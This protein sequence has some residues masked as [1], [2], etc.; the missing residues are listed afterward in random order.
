MKS[1]ILQ[2]LLL[3]S[4]SMVAVFF[5]LETGV[6]IFLRQAS[7]IIQDDSHIV[8]R[9]K[10]NL[11]LRIAADTEKLS[12]I[13]TNDHGFI[14]DEWEIE[15][16]ATTLRIA[17]LGDSFTAGHDVDY[18][19]N[20]SALLGDEL[21]EKIGEKV[22]SLNFGVP[23]QGTGHALLTY[24]H[25][26]AEFK[27]DLVILWFYMGNDFEDNL[28]FEE[29]SAKAGGGGGSLVKRIARKSQLANF[30]VNRLAKIPA[31]A[32][33]L[34]GRILTRVGHDVST[35]TGN[36][37]LALRLIFTNDKENDRALL[38]TRRLLGL[39]RQEVSADGGELLIAAIPPNF[40][41]EEKLR[42]NLFSQYPGLSELGFDPARPG[43]ELKEIAGELNLP[44]LNLTPAFQGACQ[45]T[46]ALYVCSHCHLSE[47]GHALAAERASEVVL[48]RGFIP[49]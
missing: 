41:V 2:K 45:E 18:D 19:K 8:K 1:Q 22:E 47:D 38:E 40:E 4:V 34:H 43:R 15:K 21:S 33:I 44:Y 46:C 49:R 30:I 48:E 37:P 28:I 27:P 11:D 26:A 6:R 14:G 16:D 10:E 31:V 23:G 13:R 5:V 3:L 32:N 20:F 36:V 42:E 35:E 24:R 12:H 39:L 29:G 25:Y 9:H 7:T 17:N